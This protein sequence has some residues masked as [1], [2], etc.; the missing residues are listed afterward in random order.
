MA[1]TL[2][3]A[4]SL[5]PAPVPCRT[6]P[7]FL[8]S[9]GQP[10][11]LGPFPGSAT[12]LSLCHSSP[13]SVWRHHD[14]WIAGILA[15]SLPSLAMGRGQVSLAAL[16]C[17]LSPFPPQDSACCGFLAVGEP[18]VQCHCQLH[19]PQCCLPHLSEVS[20][21]HRMQC[22]HLK[23]PWISCKNPYAVPWAQKEQG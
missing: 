6:G 19:Q 20:R 10:E 22:V 13:F 12:G 14:E 8:C 9:P 11:H 4:V 18:V 1:A 2:M 23:H 16:R 7:P 15:V 21:P 3:R 17:S 5:T